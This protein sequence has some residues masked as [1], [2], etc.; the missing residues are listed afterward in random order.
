MGRCGTTYVIRIVIPWILTIIGGSYPSRRACQATHSQRSSQESARGKTRRACC[1]ES[2]GIDCIQSPAHSV[3]LSSANPRGRRSER[4]RH[5]NR[6]STFRIRRST[7]K[8]HLV[9]PPVAYD[10]RRPAP[11]ACPVFLRGLRVWRRTD[12]LV[13]VGCARG[14]HTAVGQRVK[15][16]FRDRSAAVL[17]GSNVGMMISTCPSSPKKR[18]LRRPN[19]PHLSSSNSSGTASSVNSMQSR[20]S[21]SDRSNC[22]A[23]SQWLLLI[24]SLRN[25]RL[26]HSRAR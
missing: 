25:L 5:S 6:P 11:R 4:R 17:T 26:R 2:W 23:W 16:R 19:L 12:G 18:T 22:A 1:W 13:H 21:N 9:L 24:G 14:T 20:L 15:A 8:E 10:G 3:Q 7:D